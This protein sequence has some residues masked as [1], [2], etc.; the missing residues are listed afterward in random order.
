M[1]GA[2]FEQGRDRFAESVVRLLPLEPVFIV[3]TGGYRQSRDGGEGTALES[4]LQEARAFETL[5]L[6]KAA[7]A[8]LEIAA[9]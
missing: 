3:L 7:C 2:I 4:L 5:E 8:G 6:P 1:R 9:S